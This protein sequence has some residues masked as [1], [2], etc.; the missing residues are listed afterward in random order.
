M[1]LVFRITHNVHVSKGSSITMCKM[2]PPPPPPPYTHTQTV[3]TD[4]GEGQCCLTEIFG[5]EKYLS[6]LLKEERIAECLM[7][8]GRLFQMLGPKCEKVQKPW[9]EVLE[10]EHACV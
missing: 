3:Q 1:Y 7:S 8:W 4:N 9:V 6:S 2:Y 5:E 10:S